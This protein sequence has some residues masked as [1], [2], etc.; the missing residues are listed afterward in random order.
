MQYEGCINTVDL[1]EKN[2]F[3]CIV[4]G[5]Y[6]YSIENQ[7]KID[8]SCKN[9]IICAR[10]ILRTLKT[11]D[12][13]QCSFVGV[14]TGKRQI[15]FFVWSSYLFFYL[16][17]RGLIL[18]WIRIREISSLTLMISTYHVYNLRVINLSYSFNVVILT[19]LL[20]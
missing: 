18:K 17:K 7:F 14:S 10:H 15:Y 12:E 1:F 16:F 2:I 5:I 4:F 20:H 11:I 13:I 19:N 3:F 6:E 9:G 8:K